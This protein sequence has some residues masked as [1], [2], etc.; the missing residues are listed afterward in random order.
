MD[1][2]QIVDEAL[3]GLEPDQSSSGITANSIVEEALANF[4]GEP[5]EPPGDFVAGVKAG[6]NETAGLTRAAAATVQDALGFDEASRSSMASA[7][8]DFE[9]ANRYNKD[10]LNSPFDIR[11]DEG[12]LPFASDAVDFLQ[13]QVGKQVPNIAMVAG[14]ALT[15][16]VG[17]SAL[18]G[19]EAAKETLLTLGKTEISKKVAAE[20]AG[21]YAASAAL[22]TGGIAQEF[23]DIGV[24]APGVALTGGGIAGALEFLP[25]YNLARMAGIGPAFRG[26]FIEKLASSPLLVKALGYGGM[27]ALTEGGTEA[28][29]EIVASTA[30][31]VVDEHYDMLGPEGR[32]RILEAAITGAA[33][34]LPLGGA[35]SVFVRKKLNIDTKKIIDEFLDETFGKPQY[36]DDSAV[37]SLSENDF[38]EA[39]FERY[40]PPSDY[41]GSIRDSQPSARTR[42]PIITII[43]EQGLSTGDSQAINERNFYS[44]YSAELAARQVPPER[45]TPSQAALVKIKDRERATS[46][47]EAL[48]NPRILTGPITVEKPDAGIVI[49]GGVSDTR[50]D[51]V[52]LIAA[53]AY[54]T[55][56]QPPKLSTVLDPNTVR[57][58]T[59]DEVNRESLA[60]G[61]TILVKTGEVYDASL[62]ERAIA[63]AVETTK[64]TPPTIDTDTLDLD[65][66]FGNGIDRTKLTTIEQK[67]L[68]QLEE[69]EMTGGLSAKEYDRLSFLLDK[70]QGVDFNLP[71]AGPQALEQEVEN[72]FRATPIEDP[73]RAILDLLD[74][75]EGDVYASRV[76]GDHTFNTTVEDVRAV[77]EKIALPNAPNIVIVPHAGLLPAG[78]IRSKGMKSGTRGLFVPDTGTAYIIA[79]RNAD[80]Q[81]ITA[82][83]FHEVIGHYGLRKLLPPADYKKFVDLM[84]R[85]VPIDRIQEIAKL[86][87]VNSVNPYDRGEIAEELFAIFAEANPQ[88][89][90]VDRVVAILR[91][92]IRRVF[93]NFKYNDNEL[94]A[95][96][97]DIRRYLSAPI[98]TNN[99]ALLYPGLTYAIRMMDAESVSKYTTRVLDALPKKDWLNIDHVAQ[100]LK[101]TGAKASEAE[102]FREVLALPWMGR[103]F[104]TSDLRTEVLKRVAQLEPKTDGMQAFN[105]HGLELIGRID[106]EMMNDVEM[107]KTIWSENRIELEDAKT[108]NQLLDV[109]RNMRDAS[110]FI[111]EDS[112]FT[113]QR[114]KFSQVIEAVSLSPNKYPQAKVQEFALSFFDVWGAQVK[115][116]QAAAYL[117]V[118]IPQNIVFEA[119]F[120]TEVELLPSDEKHFDS[121]YYMGHV[122]TFKDGNGVQHVFEVQSDLFQKLDE[123]H[124]R[125]TANI[126]LDTESIASLMQQARVSRTIFNQ[127][128]R[129][130][131]RMAQEN[132]T[133]TIRFATGRTAAM[134]AGKL[135]TMSNTVNTNWKAPM[136]RYSKDFP[137][138]YAEFNDEIITDEHGW[139][140]HEIKVGRAVLPV[141]VFA[142]RVEQ[143]AAQLG[144]DEDTQESLAKF[145]SVL[146]AK[147]ASMFL[148][149]LQ[150]AKVYSIEPIKEYIAHVQNWWTTKTKLIE[151]FDRVAVDL[152][153]NKER[154]NALSRAVFEVSTESDRVGRRLNPATEVMPI[155]QK[156]GVDKF[157]RGVELFWQVDASFRKLLDRMERGLK[158]NAVVETLEDSNAARDFM[159]KWEK[160]SHA[161]KTKL[162]AQAAGNVNDKT[163]Q[164]IPRMQKIEEDI[165][166]LRNRNYFPRKR[167]GQYGVG[168]RATKDMEAFGE[169]FKAGQLILFETHET[170]AA[171]LQRVGELKEIGEISKEAFELGKLSDHEFQFLGMPPTLMETIRRD[172]QLTPAQKERLKEIEIAT[173]PGRAFLRHL[174]RRK[175]TKGYSE[176]MIRVYAAYGMSAAN[177]IARMEHHLDMGA[178]LQKI[179]DFKGP[180]AENVRDNTAVNTLFN[181]FTKHYDYILNPENDWAKIR[182]L[183][184]MWYLG[185]NVKSALVNSTQ[186]PL[187]LYPYLAER[188]GDGRSTREIAKALKDAVTI[189]RKQP[190]QRGPKISNALNAML[191]RGKQEGFIDES[192]ATELAGFTE[193]SVLERLLPVSDSG[194]LA[195]NVSYYGSWMFRQAEK[196]SRTVAFIA[197]A[198][199]AEQSG[200]TDPEQIFQVGKEAVQT[201]M[202]EYSKWNRPQFMRGKKSVVFLFWNWMQHASFLAAGGA[203]RGTAI[204]FWTMLLLAGGLQ[205]LPF[206]EDI[207]DILDKA[208]T[209]IREMLGLKNTHQDTRRSL[210]EFAK[211]D[212]SQFLGI[213]K[214]QPDLL[215]HGL[216]RYYGLGPLSALAA[217]GAPI[218]YVDISGSVSMGRYIP[219]VEE[220]LANERDPDAKFGR[221]VAAALGPVAGIPYNLWKTY[222]SSDPDTWKKWERAMPVAVKSL[223]KATRLGARGEE[224]FRGGGTVAPYDIHDME[225]RVSLLSQA[226]GFTATKLSQKYEL[227]GIKDDMR[228]YHTLRRQMLMEDYAYA[229]E[230]GN[231]EAIADARKAVYEFNQGLPD[232]AGALRISQRILSDSIKQRKRRA[233][234]R[235]LG[236]PNEKGLRAPFREVDQL[237]PSA[238]SPPTS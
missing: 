137:K 44:E 152:A 230:S 135:D 227:M 170:R 218:P 219:G 145:K 100:A 89:R 171:Q 14:A 211:D 122:R 71:D 87:E 186:I 140:W 189:F 53:S 207:L 46:T 153:G 10:H 81:S 66:R 225:T 86:Y 136:R 57:L 141:K 32:K 176:D 198:R 103:T 132:R 127:I 34:G 55:R 40:G 76:E 70:S 167:F 121:P 229:T 67:Q 63:Q 231:R 68:Q 232:G 197:A 75:T 181:Y 169:K 213:L 90:L 15:G 18:L 126:T 28:L 92:F 114:D 179:K 155:L 88:A 91:D 160:L 220:L 13:Y 105:T 206:A 123:K 223:S 159:A 11:T 185:F 150:I 182:A 4:G 60:S 37:P 35:G 95:I 97:T 199:L 78:E 111:E 93:P 50:T 200:V 195:S 128:I 59:P 216:G 130:T 157:E 16:G 183:G 118:A 175:G 83:Y 138:V 107:Q 202:F 180:I 29:Q 112:I 6:W 233:R 20:I 221:T 115:K 23:H 47:S 201:T 143:G 72:A 77:L 188:F 196:Y 205:G 31:Q 108:V 217:L 177:H 94:R 149:P 84:Y 184:F 54:K 151:E 116:L 30:R 1:A 38:V 235:T 74:N 164:L 238:A 96:V 45:R 9:Q 51:N 214:E 162:A 226:F 58:Q 163:F 24:E 203:G 27:Q 36:V 49:P 192:L 2:N 73:T 234:L 222:E 8:L 117:E 146:G 194:K 56:Q 209:G 12:V 187:T 166:K 80:A 174:L 133:E 104:L 7:Q 125:E 147:A 224:T 85:S 161:D 82:A 148:T 17:A 22:E 120:Q 172:L 212:L 139:T 26:R 62:K 64:V 190:G 48:A 208:G 98:N 39:L 19:R 204:R 109:M 131:I 144:V 42:L 154:A 165:N 79:N 173:S 21:G 99:L 65:T 191:E 129:E 228:R 25:I 102:V 193:S 69:K 237:I 43:G 156:Y 41:S 210:L 5:V 113:Q 178:A 106:R 168:I 119:P 61:G 101:A 215:T 3:A 110:S 158:Y 124:F 142:S 236:I 33:V 134:V 52:S